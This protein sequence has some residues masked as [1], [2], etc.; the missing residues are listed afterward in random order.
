[1]VSPIEFFTSYLERS[2]NRSN[3]WFVINN[4]N[5]YANIFA[6]IIPCDL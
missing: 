3:R 5:F 4:F 1:M 6:L 2:R